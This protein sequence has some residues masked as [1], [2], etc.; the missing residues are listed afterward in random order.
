[1]SENVKQSLTYSLGLI[2]GTR[3]VLKRIRKQIDQMSPPAGGQRLIDFARLM[4]AL[5]ETELIKEN[6]KFIITT[7]GEIEFDWIPARRDEI[8]ED[9]KFFL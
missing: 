4:E 7:P 6:G 9:I 2:H 5:N 1:M 3:N 8:V